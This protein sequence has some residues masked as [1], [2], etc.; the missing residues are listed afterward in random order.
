MENHILSLRNK[1][2][3]FFFHLAFVVNVEKALLFKRTTR[4]ALVCGRTFFF[5]AQSCLIFSF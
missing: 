5:P 2:S 3:L 1:N 4:H